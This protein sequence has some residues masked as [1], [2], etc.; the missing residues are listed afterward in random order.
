MGLIKRKKANR[1]IEPAR[2][3]SIPVRGVSLALLFVAAA[4]LV[5]WGAVRLTDPRVMPVRYVE[6]RG[7]LHHVSP[8]QIRDKV[9]GVMAGN[10][11]TADTGTI[12]RS[13]EAFPW[14]RRASVTRVWPDTLRVA[15]VEQRPLARWGDGALVNG[16]GQIFR[17]REGGGRPALPLLQ[18]PRADVRAVVEHYKA[19]VLRLRVLGLGIQTLALDQRHA[20]R[21]GLSNGI[22]LV[23]GQRDYEK[24]LQRFSRFYRRVLSQRAGNIDIVDL[25]YSNG[26]AVHWRD[27][28][29]A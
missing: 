8:D 7:G 4:T 6:I 19:A 25:R 23:L 17:P 2:K 26:F 1:R 3:R 10:F 9:R 28:P 18:G 22:G 21:L 29:S 24:R 5:T 16:V 15:I 20:W 11:I 13:L 14:V 12:Q 27:A